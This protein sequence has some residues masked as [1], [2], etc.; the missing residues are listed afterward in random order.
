MECGLRQRNTGLLFLAGKS[1]PSGYKAHF[2]AHS[3]KRCIRAFKC[4]FGFGAIASC[5]NHF[6]T[7]KG[8][9][10]LSKVCSPHRGLM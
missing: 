2:M 5:S 1:M 3:Y 10:I 6:S 7:S 9:A 4:P 8:A